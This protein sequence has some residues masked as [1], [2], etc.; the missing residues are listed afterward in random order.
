MIHA[1]I[2]DD[3]PKARSI[4]RHYIAELEQFSFEVREAG[5]VD[6][7][8]NVLESYT[9]DLVF[10]DVEMPG[11]SGFDL[12]MALKSPAFDVIF[13][14]AYHQYAIQAIRFSALDYLLKPVDPDELRAAIERH[15]GQ[16]APRRSRDELYD[17]LV[18]N[19][20]KQHARDFKI[21]I[22]STDG[23]HFFMIPDII[24]LEGDSSYSHIHLRNGKRFV[25]S[26]TLK[27]MEEMLEGQGFLR[28]H[29]SHLINT[30]YLSHVSA[31]H[32]MAVMSDGSEVEVAR[33]KK[34]EIKSYLKGHA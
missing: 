13:T 19:L 9:P 28:T 32:T 15:S 3:E 14:T 34:D 33:R 8:L 5:S 18:Q 12:L 6:E 23:T 24:R 17:N 20:S 22:R 25:A 7:A 16:S 21:A 26:K 2:I 10:L 27:Y 29:K 11:K 30:A 31:D 1:L 4:L